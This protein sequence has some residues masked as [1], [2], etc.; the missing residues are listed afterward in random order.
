MNPHDKHQA[1]RGM[2]ALLRSLLRDRAGNTLAIVAAAIAPLLAMVGGGIDMGRSYLSE[3]RLQSAC[4]AGV[5]AARKKLGS[6]VVA[7][8]LS[9]QLSP[10]RATNSST[11]TSGREPTAPTTAVSPGHRNGDGA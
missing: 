3:S 8:G 10:P 11:S 7:D 2:S 4:D 9:P 6:A 1:R 5:L